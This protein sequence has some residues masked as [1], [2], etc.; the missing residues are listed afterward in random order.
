VSGVHN[1]NLVVKAKARG[2]PSRIIVSTRN[3]IMCDVSPGCV[4][5][6]SALELSIILVNYNGMS[7]LPACLDS[8]QQFCPPGT[9]TIMVDNGSSDG[10][11]DLAAREYP[12]VDLIKSERNLGF[13]GGNNLAAMRASGKF[14]L[15][16]NTDTI[17]LEPLAPALSWLEEHPEYGILTVEM[18]DAQRIPRACTGRFPTPLRLAFL[19]AMLVDP[20]SYDGREACDIDWAQGSFLLIRTQLWR[21]LGGL[22]ERYFMYVEDVDL[23]KRVHDSGLK[24]AL[25]PGMRYV[26]LGGFS[27]VRFPN[28][29]ANLS[30]YVD[31]HMTGL[32]KSCSIGILLLG[33]LARVCWYEMRALFLRDEPSRTVARACRQALGKL[34]PTRRRA[35]ARQFGVRS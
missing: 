16:L 17:L 20:K 33:C 25:L 13:A 9:N 29:V 30:L 31:Q 14:M 19:R 27:A 18:L 24:C 28:Q 7:H 34:L 15:L 35:R 11:G 1:E 4:N 8:I 5:V 10:S 3:V 6:G 21:S 23:C 22:D 26:H 32:Q 2:K 12:W